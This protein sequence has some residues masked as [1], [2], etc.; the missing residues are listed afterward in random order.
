[1]DSSK[2]AIE[3]TEKN[4]ALGNFKSGKTNVLVATGSVSEKFAAEKLLPF[5]LY[6][7]DNDFWNAQIEQIYVEEDGDVLLIPCRHIVS[8]LKCVKNLD[9]C[10]LCRA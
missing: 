9:I 2:K 6:V 10:P 1:M 3:L 8:C 4:V 5:V 7:E